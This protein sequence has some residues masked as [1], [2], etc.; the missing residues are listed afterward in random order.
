MDTHYHQLLSENENYKD[1]FSVVCLVM[2]L[3]HGQ[4]SVER[5]FSVN[6]D[7][8]TPCLKEETL[9]ALRQVYDTVKALNMKMSYFR[10]SDKMLRYTRQARIRYD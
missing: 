7:F 8:L 6:E 2:V 5:G 3:S 4:A 1:L 10:V 9:A